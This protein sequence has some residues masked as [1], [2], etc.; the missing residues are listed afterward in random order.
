MLIGLCGSI[1][2]GKRTVASY[3]V[4]QHGFVRLRLTPPSPTSDL[5]NARAIV[6]GSAANRSEDYLF[7]TVDQ[8]VEFITKRW[9]QLW[10]TTEVW[11]EDILEKLLRRPSFLLVSVD[12][13]LSLRWQRCKSRSHFA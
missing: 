2:A 4:K 12:A 9:Q 8:L 5:L 7:D 11:N 1:S 3:L 10:V 13:P 6:T